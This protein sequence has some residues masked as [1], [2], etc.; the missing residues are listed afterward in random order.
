M[1]ESKCALSRTIIL[2]ID[3]GEILV[4]LFNSDHNFGWKQCWSQQYVDFPTHANVFKEFGRME[5]H[6]KYK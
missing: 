1:L 2:G 4:Q 6:I 3:T 5:C